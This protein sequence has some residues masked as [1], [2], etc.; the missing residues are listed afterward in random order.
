MKVS[1]FKKFKSWIRQYLPLDYYVH[2]KSFSQH[3]ED[4]V[5]AAFFYKNYKGVYINIGAHHPFRFSNTYYFLQERL[6]WN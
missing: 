1:R 3:G 6:E 5:L 4:V 2:S